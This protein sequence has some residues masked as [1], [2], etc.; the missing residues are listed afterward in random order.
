MGITSEDVRRCLS[1]SLQLTFEI[2]EDGHSLSL[3]ET[4]LGLLPLSVHSVVSWQEDGG[5]QML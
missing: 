4:N 2:T 5:E 3:Q 1:N